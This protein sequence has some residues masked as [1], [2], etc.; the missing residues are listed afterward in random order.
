M[1]FHYCLIWRYWK[2]FTAAVYVPFRTCHDIAEILLKSINQSIPLGLFIGNLDIFFWSHWMIF[3]VSINKPILILKTISHW[4]WYWKISVKHI[5]MLQKNY[6]ISFDIRIRHTLSL[7]TMS[8]STFKT[9][10]IL[11]YTLQ[12]RLKPTYHNYTFMSDIII[13]HFYLWFWRRRI[14]NI[15]LIFNFYCWFLRRILNINLILNFYR[16][17]LRRRI[18]NINLILLFRTSF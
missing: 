10:V 18:L 2:H 13:K 12:L 9:T 3:I 17:F 4:F 8:V 16:W 7:V 11:Y 6:I 14:L 1:C 5:M 15:N